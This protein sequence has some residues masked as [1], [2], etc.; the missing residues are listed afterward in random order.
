MVQFFKK[1]YN[2]LYYCVKLN[3]YLFE[4]PPLFFLVL[5]RLLGFLLDSRHV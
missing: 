4:M 1:N 5:D 3:Y 2:K